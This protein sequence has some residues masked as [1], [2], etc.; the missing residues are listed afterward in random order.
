MQLS[1]S[2]PESGSAVTE[3]LQRAKK[4]QIGEH[5]S[6][7]RSRSLLIIHE[8]SDNNTSGSEPASMQLHAGDGSQPLPSLL[9]N[10]Q[11]SEEAWNDF[12]GID[13]DDRHENKN[14]PDLLF[15]RQESM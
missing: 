14:H 3:L 5:Y 2:C 15:F 6:R 12:C 10:V 8:D 13:D 9:I 11:D 7:S 1:G 4:P